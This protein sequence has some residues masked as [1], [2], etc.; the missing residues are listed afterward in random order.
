M[1]WVAKNSR[2]LVGGLAVTVALAGSLA[3]VVLPALATSPGAAIP[4][5]SIPKNVTPINVA[6]GGQSDDCTVFYP[7]GGKPTYQYRIANPKT[8]TY[9]TRVDGVEVTFT[10]TL[11]PPNPPPGSGSLPAYASDKYVSFTSTNAGIVDVGI[12]GGADT[13]RYNYAGAPVP[14]VTNPSYGSVASDGYLHA[15]AQSVDASGNPTQLYSVS[16]LTFCFEVMGS[17]SGTV[18]GDSN[19]NG[20]RDSGELGQS[21]WTVKVYRHSSSTLVGTTTS[22]AD[23]SYDVRVPFSTG[24]Q[25]R[26]CETPP[27]AASGWAQTQPLPSSD[28]VCSAAGELR[29]GYVLTPTSPTQEISG[30][31]FGNVSGAVTCAQPFGLSNY[32]VYF[33]TCKPNT[34]VF[35]SGT[36]SGGQP[37]VS[38][39]PVDQTQ[40][41]VPVVERITFPFAATTVGGVTAHRQNPFARLSAG[42]SSPS[43]DDLLYDDVFPFS[44]ADLKPMLI[45][46]LDPRI[47]SSEFV[48]Q[49]SP[50]NYGSIS[51]AGVVI[52]NYPN[53][54]S[55]LIQATQAAGG[56]YTAYVYSALDGLR[57]TAP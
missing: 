30:K 50:T 43:W 40:P 24:V 37:Y 6:T 36:Y 54:T 29:K 42:T 56:A 46:N 7:G 31:H 33:H 34:Y 14:G 53:E 12:K 38:V 47:A 49:T 19:Q 25:Y 41:K 35:S 52:P 48:L 44:R 27:G 22:A 20:A 28:N 2:K 3:L 55:C 32:T 39:W 11:N 15:P 4:P 1:S 45:C 10:L 57:S 51:N 18:Y 21:G 17:V 23:G 16:N 13:S 8:K 5:P 9:T 26:V